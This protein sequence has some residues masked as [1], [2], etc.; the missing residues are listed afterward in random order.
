MWF[1]AK[2]ALTEIRSVKSLKVSL[3][4]AEPKLDRISTISTAGCSNYENSHQQENNGERCYDAVR[5]A[6]DDYYFLD[7]FNPNAWR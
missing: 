3:I 5:T 2:A 1:D 6:F 7:G 4:D